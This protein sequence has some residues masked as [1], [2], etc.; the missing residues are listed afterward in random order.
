MSKYVD[1]GEKKIL[2]VYNPTNH[3]I[4]SQIITNIFKM[5]FIQE[6]SQLQLFFLNYYLY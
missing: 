4:N 3:L 1:N 5:Y 2:C 6:V